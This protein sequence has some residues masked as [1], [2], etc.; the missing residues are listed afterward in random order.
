MPSSI[1][2]SSPVAVLVDP[3]SDV[4]TS[5]RDMRLEDYLNDKI[6]TMTD[7]SNLASLIETVEIQKKQL[8]QQVSGC[9]SLNDRLY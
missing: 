9:L 8:D 4:P 6:Q 3:K 2:D 1:R 7:L 5:E